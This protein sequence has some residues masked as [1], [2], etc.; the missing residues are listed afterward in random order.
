MSRILGLDLGTNSIGWALVDEEN[1]EIIDTGVRIFQEGVNRD[2]KGAEVSKNET[3]RDKRLAR[4]QLF[5]TKL[6]KQILAEELM[7]HGMFPKVENIGKVLQNTELPDELKDFFKLDPYELRAKGLNEKLT[8]FEIGRILYHIAQRRG[9]KSNRQA[10]KKEEGKVKTDIKKTAEEIG[11]HQTL[12]EYLANLNP[13]EERIRNR[14]TSRDMY[15]EEFE[16]LWEV[17]SKFHDFLTPELKEKIG[18]P[19]TGILF[20]QRPLKSQ[21]HLIGKCQF[22]PN[23]TKSPISAIPFELFR[24]HQFINSIEYDDGNSLNQEQREQILELMNSQKSNF[25]F[26][27]LKK[28]LNLESRK[29]N[30]GDKDKVPANPTIAQLSKLF[31]KDWNQFNTKQ[32]DEIWHVF[33]EASSNEWLKNYAK[34][35]WNFN[36]KQAEKATKV[37]LKQGFANL[38]RKA[39]NNILP[40]LE[41]GLKYHEAVLLGGVKGAFGEEVWEKQQDKDLITNTVIDISRN[42]QT[43]GVILDELK[44]FLKK[45]FNFTDKQ[46]NKLYHHSQLNQ[47]DSVKE[48]LPEPKDVKNP[49]VNQSLL[50]L[51]TLVNS[52]IEAYGK[53]DRIMVELA[54]NLKSSKQERKRIRFKNHENQRENEEARNELNKHGLRHSRENIHKYLLWKELKS[55]NGLACCPYTGQSISY[56]ELFG[57]KFQIEHIIPWS[58]SLDDSFNN[59][60]LC[61]VNENRNKGDLTPFQFYGSNEDKWAE[62]KA[63]AKKVLP[64]NKYRK[65][66]STKD[67]NADNFISRQLND[68]R[69]IS[70]EAKNYLQNICKDVRVAQGTLT[71]ELRQKWGLNSILSRDQ[72]VKT[73]DDHRHHA[74][75]A[76]TV[77]LTKTR[78]LN[79]ISRWNPY[80]RD[81]ETYNFPLPWKGF[82]QQAYE[83]IHN[84]LISHRYRNRVTTK[85]KKKIKKNGKLYT[86]QGI[87]A[88]GGLHEETFYGK[89]HIDEQPTYHVRV[90]LESIDKMAKVNRIVDRN[91]KQKIIDRLKEVGFD[92]RSKDKIPNGTFFSQDKNSNEKQPLISLPNRNG[93]NVPVK[94]VR[95]KGTSSNIRQVKEDVN[96]WVEPGN[97]HHIVIYKDAQGNY[98]EEPVTFWEAVQRKNRGKPVVNKEPENGAQFVTSLEENEMFVIGLTDEELWDN[99]DNPQFLSPYLY[100]VQKVS[101]S[102]YNFRHHLASTI[103]DKSTLQRIQSFKKW[104][105][106]NPIKVRINRLGQVTPI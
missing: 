14:Y 27:R 100:R 97:N 36:D 81:P 45:E 90:S 24:A 74:V 85:V 11:T 103:E 48:Y 29:F 46:L 12:G 89:R 96:K 4:R 2:T 20:Y 21:K 98:K 38:S 35:N 62:V 56:E 15:E 93:K 16:K 26:I 51:R 8:P 41:Q 72:K 77:A 18:N 1:E 5:R 101:S 42:N 64:F 25:D 40:F 71:K 91:I 30:Y 55:Q 34:G 6:R 80:Y 47:A 17:Q 58:V 32:K 57:G 37:S 22:E 83:A 76:I 39:I 105:N 10:E 92:T 59:K 67:F 65:F 31:G 84:I 94:K 70:K 68:T 88:R 49:I 78:Y 44:G 75:D 7:K 104:E 106:V 13:H 54:R 28:A 60:T 69:Y 43:E 3:R 9:F 53:P 82:Y 50:E 79:E 102:D 66:V 33:Y 61:E 95:L 99:K 23:K 19:K 86:A 87:A 52:V 63:R 73:R